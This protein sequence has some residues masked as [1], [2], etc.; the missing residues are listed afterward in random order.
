MPVAAVEIEV[1][2]QV[3]EPQTRDG[4]HWRVFSLTLGKLISEFSGGH[5]CRTWHRSCRIFVRTPFS[6]IASF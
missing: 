2:L 6:D 4:R 3:Y 1:S 5:L